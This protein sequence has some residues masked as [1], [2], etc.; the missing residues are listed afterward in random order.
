MLQIHVKPSKM[1]K[2]KPHM[3]AVV[4]R[5]NQQTMSTV[6]SIWQDIKRKSWTAGTQFVIDAQFKAK[7]LMQ[8]TT[9]GK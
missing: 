4:A 9:M 2:I 8:N 7:K 1:P 5:A 3:T 6:S